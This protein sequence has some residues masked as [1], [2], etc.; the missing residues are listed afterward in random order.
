[1]AL[2]MQKNALCELSLCILKIPQI[3]LILGS[4]RDTDVGQLVL[5]PEDAKG[6]HPGTSFLISCE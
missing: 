1:M 3:L 2:K 5:F 6:K 4:K